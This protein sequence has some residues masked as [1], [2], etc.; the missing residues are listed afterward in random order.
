LF[1]P[2]QLANLISCGSFSSFSHAS[3]TTGP[4]AK[5]YIKKKK[6]KK[7]TPQKFATGQNSIID[8]G[9]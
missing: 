6:K 8:A 2:Q 9:E 7:K 1:P 5:Q 3:K 4:P